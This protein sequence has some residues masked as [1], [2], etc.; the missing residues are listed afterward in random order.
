MQIPTL[1]HHQEV[2]Q[3]TITDRVIDRYLFNFLSNLYSAAPVPAL[4][5]A[6]T[7]G[8]RHTFSYMPTNGAYIPKYIPNQYTY[9]RVYR[10][11]AY[12]VSLV[13]SRMRL[14]LKE[15]FQNP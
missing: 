10:T 11:F 6:H 1:L 12:N 15:F 8:L 9:M 7:M 5:D 4:L 3:H 2:R 14:L 13:N